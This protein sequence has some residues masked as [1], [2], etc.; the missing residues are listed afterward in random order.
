M[1]KL[2][3]QPFES[4]L[5]S[6]EPLNPEQAQALK[7]HLDGCP[8]CRSLTTAWSE[9]TRFIQAVQPVQPAPGFSARWQVRLAEQRTTQ[10]ARKQRRLS[11]W[12]MALWFSG[13]VVLIGLTLALS[14]PAELVLTA[15]SEIAALFTFFDFTKDLLFTLISTAF[16]LTPPFLWVI[17][18]G[19]LGVLSIL[20]IISLRQIVEAWRIRL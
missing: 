15:F 17:G 10:L 1:V 12:M 7:E 4:W 18:L 20:W 8:A 19:G 3:H 11:I 2:E 5:L 16:T 9:V 14:S 13:A 6:G